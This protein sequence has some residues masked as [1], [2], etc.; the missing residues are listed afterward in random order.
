MANTAAAQAGLQTNP[1]HSYTSCSE[2]MN[3]PGNFSNSTETPRCH[4]G[5]IWKQNF[6][7]SAESEAFD[8]EGI[9][10]FKHFSGFQGCSLAN[11]SHSQLL[12]EAPGPLGLGG[13]P[14]SLGLRKPPM[15]MSCL[16]WPGPCLTGFW[17]NPPPPENPGPNS[18]KYH[19]FIPL[20]LSHA[21][22][23]KLIQKSY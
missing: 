7:S 11:S 4:T 18:H 15:A 10:E 5:A 3:S 1:N 14:V 13:R 8:P 21:L 19:V 2:G 6:K 20:L 17:Q 23:E 16:S 9:V 12:P 22:K